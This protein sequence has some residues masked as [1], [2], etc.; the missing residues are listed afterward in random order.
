[1]LITDSKDASYKASYEA[2][3]TKKIGINTFNY[4]MFPLQF[5][6]E[7]EASKNRC[8][9]HRKY[10]W[11]CIPILKTSQ[12]VLPYWAQVLFMVKSSLRCA[13]TAILTWLAKLKKD[14]P[15]TNRVPKQILK[16]HRMYESSVVLISLSLHYPISWQN[17]K[18]WSKDK[19]YRVVQTI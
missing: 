4:W 17:L 15:D 5:Q 13:N 6:L 16:I 19:W 1:M 9:G 18:T 2:P 7:T 3:L 11:F 14:R 8:S 10:L 12:L